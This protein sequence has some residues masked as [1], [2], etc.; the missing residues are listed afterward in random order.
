MWTPTK[1][2]I[3]IYGIASIM[4]YLHENNIIHRDLKLDNI[5]LDDYLFPKISDFGLSKVM[6]RNNLNVLQSS[7]GI[8]GTIVYLAP[9]ILVDESDPQYSK[10][11]DVYAY[12]FIVYEMFTKKK[13]DI[14]NSYMQIVNFVTSGQHPPINDSVPR[15][16]KNLINKCWSTSPSDRPTFKQIVHEIETNKEFITNDIDEND[17]RNYIK[18]V[19]S[20]ADPN[21]PSNWFSICPSSFFTSSRKLKKE[22]RHIYRSLRN[23]P[24]FDKF[25]K[26]LK[27]IIISTINEINSNDNKIKF[28][29]EYCIILYAKNY[30]DSPE[31]IQILNHLQIVYFELDYPY[32]VDDLF[33][34]ISGL[35]NSN[36]F[37]VNIC[38]NI[39]DI[40]VP[41]KIA[42]C[43][44][45]TRH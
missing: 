39:S 4:S 26:E 32:S 38:L 24:G 17:F 3:H 18:L 7:K 27:D 30:F 28:S 45:I 41:P 6:N 15:C 35:S 9:E 31:F 40:S 44:I 37:S 2:L 1:M 11:S 5:L 13:T 33:E 43:I 10:A 34:K 42:G 21:D 29:N 20:N 8:K 25:D 22:L 14:G 23:I 12:A 16:Y 19:N 36:D